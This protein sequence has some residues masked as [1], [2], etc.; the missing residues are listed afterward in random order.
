MAG[1]GVEMP[2]R[3]AQLARLK[4]HEGRMLEAAKSK[5][6]RVGGELEELRR[7]QVEMLGAMSSQVETFGALSALGS[8]SLRNVDRRIRELAGEWDRC[9]ADA[10]RKAGRTKVVERLHA[11]ADFERRALRDKSDLLDQVELALI[12]GKISSA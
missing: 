6:A 4:S 5:A 7:R 2:K 11:A 10:L 3:T 9:K 1:L 12:F 8:T